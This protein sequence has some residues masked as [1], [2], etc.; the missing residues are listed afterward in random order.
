VVLVADSGLGTINLVRLGAEALDGHPVVVMLNRY[1][2]GDLHR[3]NRS[4]L[5][6]RN[7]LD[8]VTDI[9]ALA[10]RCAPH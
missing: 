4:W 1:D 7:G 6:D 10:S 3:R 9:G 8:V 5:S 2:D